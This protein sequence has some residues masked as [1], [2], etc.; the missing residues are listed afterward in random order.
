MLSV[1]SRSLPVWSAACRCRVGKGAEKRVAIGSRDGARSSIWKFTAQ[2][3]EVYI[4]SRLWGADSKVSLHSSGGCSWARTDRW[5]KEDPTRRNPDRHIVRWHV[6]Q[7]EGTAALHVFRLQIPKSEL[8]GPA[9]PLDKKR[10]LWI[11]NVPDGA[12]VS[13]ECYVTPPASIDP[14]QVA[15]LPYRHLFSLRLRNHCWFVVLIQMLTLSLSE[16]EQLKAAVLQEVPDLP[17]LQGES[18]RGVCFFQNS[19]QLHGMIEVAL[20]ET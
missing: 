12:T 11:D 14:A 3:N 15:T 19:Q 17:A 6:G 8:R 9:P 13:L 2:G 16:L 5:V 7:I 4:V 10:V 18:L 1:C 20:T